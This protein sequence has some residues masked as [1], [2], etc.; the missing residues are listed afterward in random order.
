MDD[1]TIKLLGAVGI[2]FLGFIISKVG[3]KILNRSYRKRN[4]LKTFKK[5]P[6]SSLFSNVVITL[7]IFVALFFLQITITEEFFL[8][9]Y[10]IL[11]DVLSFVLLISLIIII[12]NI[13]MNVIE[14]I[15]D[16]SGLSN[17]VKEYD[18]GFIFNIFLGILRIILYAVLGIFALNSLGIAGNVSTTLSYVLY[19]MFVFLLVIIFYG[20]KEFVANFFAGMYIKNSPNFQ[21]GQRMRYKDIVGTIEEVNNDSVMISTESG[22]NHYIPNQYF[23]KHIISF[24]EV[25]TDIPTL[26]EIKENYVAQTPSFCGPASAA[27]VLDIFGY[28]FTQ[29]QIGKEAGAEVGKGTKPDMLIKAV[30]KLTKKNVIGTWINIDMINNLREEV[31]SWLDDDALIIIDYKKNVLFPESK[32]A[33]YSIALAVEGEELVVLDPSSKKGGVFLADYKKIERGM[34]TYSELIG[35]KRGYIVLAP[36]DSRAYNRIKQGLIYSDFN[37]YTKLNR[38][39]QKSFNELVKKADFLEKIIPGRVRDFIDKK[40]QKEKIS[41]VWRPKPRA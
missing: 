1:T 28:G 4:K 34:D 9:I 40:R 32:G 36:K 25:D 22:Y 38:R 10:N 13:L 12:V 23:L 33:H 8:N 39:L 24:K 27:M 5:N 3:S 2:L 29:E 30:E 15:M 41:R 7:S 14:K 35:G 17:L 20:T 6:F 37:L 18:H 11:P 16:K 21:V 26:E 31:M 19:P